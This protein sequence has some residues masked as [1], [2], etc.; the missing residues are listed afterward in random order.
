MRRVLI[1]AAVIFALA[2]S[3][4]ADQLAF[5]QDEYFDCLDGCRSVGPPS[6]ICR[7]HCKQGYNSCLSSGGYCVW[8]PDPGETCPIV[9]AVPLPPDPKS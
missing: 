2:A 1:I 9:N 3:V 5:C 4:S 8:P 6:P 7:G